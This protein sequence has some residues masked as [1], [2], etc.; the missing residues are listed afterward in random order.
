MKKIMLSH[1]A[2][3]CGGKLIGADAE[4]SGITIDSRAV[5]GGDLFV[6]IK[7]ERFDGHAFI[8]SAFE[9]GA[10]GCVANNA[11]EEPCILVEDTLEAYQAI[12]EYYRSLFDIP[13]IGVTGSVGKTTTKEMIWSALSTRLNVLKN[14]GNLNNQTGVP[15]TI[16]RLEEEH[17][18]AIVE[19]GTN[20]FGEVRALAKIG[21][22]N[23]CVLTNIGEAHIEFLGSRE[24]I[25][26]AKCEMMEH[27]AEGGYI[28]ACGDDDFLK[29]L[30][31]MYKNVI[32]YGLEEHNDLIAEDVCELGLEGS[33]FKV[34]DTQVF[35]PAPGKH[36]IKN[37]LAAIAVARILG[38][39]AEDAARGIAGFSSCGSRMNV[40]H[41]GSLTILDDAY[42]ANP[43]SMTASIGVCA[44]AK[45]RR[46]CILGDMLELGDAAEEAHRRIGRISAES[47]DLTVCVGK[48]SEYMF[49]E[50]KKHGDA[51][52]FESREE[53]E[54]AIKGIILPGDTVL[55][56]AS[57]SIGL[58]SVSALLS[59]MNI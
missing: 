33:R 17:Q 43:T 55:I 18:A 19:M 10:V 45:G 3:A 2:A 35:V 51:L 24:G 46:V 59:E 49:D 42:N 26:R 5:K 7:G 53:L 38:I 48:L 23:I 8:K 1:A 39:S 21:R 34:G 50:A 52:H 14:E 37:A 28:V 20:H 4:I 32:L 58:K 56:K 40:M 11:Q 47:C 41:A 16:F 13:L 15:T 44:M 29:K 12:A 22:P 54:S 27:M 36:M 57:N 30:K 25:F 31:G 9:K 6:A